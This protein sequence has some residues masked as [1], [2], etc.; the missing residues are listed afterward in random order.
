MEG[1]DMQLF[2]KWELQPTIT[3]DAEIKRVRMAF[4]A[5]IQMLLASGRVQVSGA[6]TDCRGGYFVLEVDQ[7]DDLF[8]L[9]GPP[10]LDHFR[11]ETHP[12]ASLETLTDLLARQVSV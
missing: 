11:L 9:L 2:A 1:F 10:I 5:Q 7:A 12:V 4:G 3:E 6:F 8:Q